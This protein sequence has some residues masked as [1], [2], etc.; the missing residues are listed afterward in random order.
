MHLVRGMLDEVDAEEGEGES[1]VGSEI[2]GKVGS[3]LNDDDL[4]ILM[5]DDET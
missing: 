3:E 4:D 2:N 5:S 1:V